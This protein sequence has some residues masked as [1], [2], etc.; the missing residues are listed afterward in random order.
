M[1][2]TRIACLSK[3]LSGVFLGRK[4]RRWSN[5]RCDG[6]TVGIMDARDLGR[7]L[8]ETDRG[9]VGGES[10][11]RRLAEDRGDD[12][13][14][15]VPLNE[16]KEGG[17]RRSFPSSFSLRMR[18]PKPPCFLH[19][20]ATRSAHSRTF[21]KRTAPAS[22]MAKGS[23]SLRMRTVGRT[24]CGISGGS[25]VAIITRSFDKCFEASSEVSSLSGGADRRK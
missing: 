18:A 10:G 11:R 22:S 5:G 9:R 17:G 8:A 14:L 25:W 6:S 4:F 20:R 7:N 13:V 21:T 23:S 1:V 19:T 3:A 12:G 2:V 15:W 24:E 16:R